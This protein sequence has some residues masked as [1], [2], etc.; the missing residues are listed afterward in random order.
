MLAKRH[1]LMVKG[2]EVNPGRQDIGGIF[3]RGLCA[4]CNKRASQYDN[5]ARLQHDPKRGRR[6]PGPVN[7]T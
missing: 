4:G 6:R 7:A 5:G 3:F 1:R 2:N